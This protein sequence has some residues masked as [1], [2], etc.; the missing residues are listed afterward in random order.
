MHLTGKQLLL[1]KVISAGNDDGTNVD[2][3]QLIERVEYETTKQSIQF[4]IRALI[5]HGLIEK[6]GTDKR[7]GRQRVTLGMTELGKTYFTPTFPV[8]AH[9]IVEPELSFSEE[10][11]E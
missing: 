9:P 6:T 11:Y 4:S 3:D 7:R 5:K 2:L 10:S 8:P 1:L